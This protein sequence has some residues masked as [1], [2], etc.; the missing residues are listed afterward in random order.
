M[1]EG[2]DVLNGDPSLVSSDAK[3]W[4]IGELQMRLGENLAILDHTEIARIAIFLKIPTTQAKI[5]AALSGG[6]AVSR[7][8][9]ANCFYRRPIEEY[10]EGITGVCSKYPMLSVYISKLRKETPDWVKIN[11]V[12]GFGYQCPPDTCAGLKEIMSGKLNQSIG[13]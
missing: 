1:L 8:A 5:L 9:L 12:W 6:K 13:A 4:W 11:V 2:V 10:R 3:D 7:G